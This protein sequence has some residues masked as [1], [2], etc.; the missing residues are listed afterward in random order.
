MRYAALALLLLVGCGSS[1]KFPKGFLFGTAIAGFQA[2]MGC[3]TL[4]ASQC[5]DPHSDWYAFITRTP[6]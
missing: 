5:E 6:E 1:D 3:P 2:D 4:P